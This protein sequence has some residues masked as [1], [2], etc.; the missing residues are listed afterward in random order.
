[1][2]ENIDL[3]AQ[4]IMNFDARLKVGGGNKLKHS[5]CAYAMAIKT[6]MLMDILFT[7]M[8]EKKIIQSKLLNQENNVRL[9]VLKRVKFL[10][11]LNKLV[12]QKVML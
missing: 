9:F 3:Y 2:K 6:E 1:M 11:L 5:P 10:K 4:R 12:N 7:T 8:K